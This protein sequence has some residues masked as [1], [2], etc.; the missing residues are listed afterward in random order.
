MAVTHSFR[1]ALSGFNREDVVHYLEYLNTKHNTQINQLNSE[2]EEL[3]KE[4]EALKAI[5]E[6]THEKDELEANCAQ[7]QAENEAL[8]AKLSEAEAEVQ[9]LN[10]LLAEHEQNLA[11]KELEAYRRAEQAERIAKERAEQIYQQATGTLA[12]ATTQVDQAAASFRRIADQVSGQM[13]QLQLAV[14]SSRNALLDAATTMYAIRP[15]VQ[16]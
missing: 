3:R 4:L 10:A 14:D 15:G 12:Q 6:D 1:K 2:A 16:E 13:S 7:L 9:R 5:P 11:S 8:T